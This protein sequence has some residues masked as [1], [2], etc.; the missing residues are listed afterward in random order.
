MKHICFVYHLKISEKFL[1]S[2]K[3]FLSEKNIRYN[4]LDRAELAKN[5]FKTTDLII[6]IGG[7]GTFLR[8][9]HFNKDKLQLGLNQFPKKKEG[10]FTRTNKNKFKKDII[11]ILKGKFK[12]LKLLRL[13]TKINENTVPDLA[14]NEFYIGP[15]KPYYLFNYEL[16]I[17]KI[18]EYQRSSGILVGTPS[19]SYAW[20][21]SAGGKK[22][23]LESDNFQL[24]VREPYVGK[25]NKKPEVINVILSKNQKIKIRIKS[26]QGILVADSVSNEY[27]FNE[28]DTI[29][30]KPSPHPLRFVE[31]L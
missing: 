22:M 25:L 20:L 23:P 15:R 7:D 3:K 4:F 30:V 16:K 31:I 13:Q 19:G 9:S 24:L 10:F 5:C 8:A 2:V 1:K 14:L 27:E 29:E 6:T 26:F 12:I 28:L 18:N 21:D 11:K 17:R